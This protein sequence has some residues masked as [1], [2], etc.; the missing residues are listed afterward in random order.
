MG[1]EN[2]VAL[3]ERQ[4][5]INMVLMISSF[6]NRLRSTIWNR[7]V[8]FFFQIAYQPVNKKN[9]K[10]GSFTRWFLRF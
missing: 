8:W 1:W 6:L 10:S 9:I 3:Q 4:K 7:R 2:R 5:S